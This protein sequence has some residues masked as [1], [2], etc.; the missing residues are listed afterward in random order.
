MFPMAEITGTCPRSTI[1]FIRSLHARTALPSMRMPQEPQIIILQLFRYASEPSTV[2]TMSRTSSRQ[3]HSGASTSYSRS[4]RSPES[5]SNLQI[6][7][8]TSTGLPSSLRPDQITQDGH[9]PRSC[10][11]TFTSTPKSKS[12]V[13]TTA[14]VPSAPNPYSW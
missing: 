9:L 8:A 6:F 13:V 2:V 7:S 1:G 3:A 14:L 10:A 5:G 11:F 12:S 4:T